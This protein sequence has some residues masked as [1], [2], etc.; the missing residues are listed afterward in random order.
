MPDIK[1]KMISII[2]SLPHDKNEKE[3]VEEFLTK[4]M[5]HKSK[6]QFEKGQYVN[7]ESVKKEFLND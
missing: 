1:E 5:L 7:H 3:L 2:N 4:L 6:E